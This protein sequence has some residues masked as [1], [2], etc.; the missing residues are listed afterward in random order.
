VP[1]TL[2]T[3]EIVIQEHAQRSAVETVEPATAEHI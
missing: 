2:A 3:R 1:R